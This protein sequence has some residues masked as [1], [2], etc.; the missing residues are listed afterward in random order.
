MSKKDFDIQQEN[1]LYEFKHQQRLKKYKQTILNKVKHFNKEV[2]DYKKNYPEDDITESYRYTGAICDEHA[3]FNKQDFGKHFVNYLWEQATW[4]PY[5]FTFG[6]YKGQYVSKLLDKD[7]NY[8]RWFIEN[9]RGSDNL[10]TLQ[11]IDYLLKK[12]SADNCEEKDIPSSNYFFGDFDT[13]YKNILLETLPEKYHKYLNKKEILKWF[14]YDN[15]RKD[16]WTLDEKTNWCASFF[17]ANY[18]NDSLKEEQCRG[19]DYDDGYDED[20]CNEF[21]YYGDPILDYGD[22]C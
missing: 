10:N 21:C 19:E 22:L 6:K 5:I 20:F 12:L 14:K 3:I 15:K 7:S 16:S 1:E 4:C 18:H 11:I 13:M 9:V 17:D 8:C 2:A